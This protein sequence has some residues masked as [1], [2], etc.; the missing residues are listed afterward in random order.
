MKISKNEITVK[1]PISFDFY[2]IDT[3]KLFLKTLYEIEEYKNKVIFKKDKLITNNRIFRSNNPNFMFL[4]SYHRYNLYFCDI[5]FDAPNKTFNCDL[6]TE[7]YIVETKKEKI[8]ISHP[9]T[10]FCEKNK[11]KNIVVYEFDIYFEKLVKIFSENKNNSE[12]NLLFAPFN[13]E[14]ENFV[15]KDDFYSF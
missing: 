4:P 11:S 9:N 15:K 1:I 5:N 14:K 10:I 3:N 6:Y 12:L 7:N 2:N 8:L 13:S